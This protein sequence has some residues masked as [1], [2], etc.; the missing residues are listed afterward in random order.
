M[1]GTVALG[2]GTNASE[3]AYS[4][5]VVIQEDFHIPNPSGNVAASTSRAT[6]LMD[7]SPR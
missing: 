6:E 4:W 7:L 2:G 3:T 5:T 1:A